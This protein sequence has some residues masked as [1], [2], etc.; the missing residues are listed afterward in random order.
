[1]SDSDYGRILDLRETVRWAADHG[2]FS[3]LRGVGDARWSIA[4]DEGTEAAVGM[5]GAVSLGEIGILCHLA[6][7]DNY[8]K[9]G[10]GTRLSSWAVSYLRSRGASTVRL[11]STCQAEGLYRSLGFEPTSRRASYR[12]EGGALERA[13]QALRVG[14][15]RDGERRLR[16]TPLLGGDLPEVYGA[17]RWSFGWFFF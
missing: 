10:L 9:M 11:D 3:L 2:A 8:R 1:M 17:D 15:P 16:V 5:V 6:V 14:G 13:A 7:H 4:E 12:L